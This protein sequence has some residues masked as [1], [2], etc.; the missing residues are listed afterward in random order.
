VDVH[1]NIINLIF[2][3]NYYVIRFNGKEY[4]DQNDLTFSSMFKQAAV[5]G[6]LWGEK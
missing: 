5:E 6:F 4:I 2:W 1:P 3:D